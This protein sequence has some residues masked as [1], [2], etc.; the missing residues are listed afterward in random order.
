MPCTTAVMVRS[1]YI[2]VL[3]GTFSCATT[4]TTSRTFTAG[5][6][7][8][9]T[10]RVESVHEVVQRTEGNPVGGAAAGAL[11]GGALFRRS[12]PS[13]VFGATAGAAAGAALS[14]GSTEQRAYEVRVRLDDGT[15]GV[16]DYR[17][18]SPFRPGDRVVVT[19]GGLARA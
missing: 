16:F 5:S 9:M 7:I 11:I 12:G 6:E 10:G 4:T 18:Y 13:T 14:S 8:G 17:G 1:L 15:A 2:G 3:L 19:N